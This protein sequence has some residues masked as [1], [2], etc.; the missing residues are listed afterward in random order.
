MALEAPEQVVERRL[1][2][3]R[4]RLR[5]IGLG[6]GLGRTWLAAV[7]AL[8]GVVAL[9]Y[10]LN[11]PAW[12]RVVLTLAAVAGVLWLCWRWMGQGLLHRLSLSDVAGRVEETFPELEDRLRSA[13]EFARMDAARPVAP[14]WEGES[15]TLRQRVR[16]EAAERVAALDLRRAADATPAQRWL[17]RGGACA[18]VVA[19]LAA[20]MPGDYRAAA[21]QRLTDPFAG[22][23]WPKRTLIAVV[24]D[25]PERVAAGDRVGVR[26]RLERGDRPSA[27]AT[28]FYQYDNGAVRQELMTR[29]ADGTFAA[30]LDARVAGDDA[31]LLRVWVRA[32]DDEKRLPTVTVVPRLAVRRV[33]LE[34]APP[35]Y[36]RGPGGAAAEQFDLTRSAVTVVEGSTVRL[37]A[38]FNKPLGEHFEVGGVEP[39]PTLTR[40]G[41]VGQAL[42]QAEKSARLSL[43]ATDTDGFAMALAGEY[44]LLVRPDQMPSV[45]IERPRR[46]EERTARA[47]VPLEAVAEDDFAVVSVELRV[48]RLGDGQR[49]TIPLMASGEAAAGA[50][51]Q[52]V[53]SGPGRSRVRLLYLWSLAELFPADA[54]GGLR[55]GDVLEYHLAAKDNFRLPLPGGDVRTHPEATSSR[56]RIVIVS[57]AELASRL[58]DEMRQMAGQV[59]QLR[60]AQRRTSEETS[61]LRA[62]VASAGAMDEARQRQARRLG[63][64]QST[65]ASQSRQLAG[66]LDDL[67]R[68]MAENRL[69]ASELPS[70]ARDVRDLLDRAAEGPMREATARL[71]DAREM[72]EAAPRDA[73]LQQTQDRQADAQAML[74]Q[75]AERLGSLGTLSQAMQTLQRLLEEQQAVGR[76]TRELAR[77]NLGRRPEQ[78]SAEDREKLRELSSRQ[79][80]L[81]RRTEEALQQMEQ[82]A[83]QMEGSDPQGAQALREAG[84]AGRQQNVASAQQRAGSA[85]SQNQPNNAQPDQR[86]AEIG[87]QMMLRQLREAE[88]RKLETLSRQLAELAEQVGILVRR[89]AG[90]NLDNLLLRPE[91]MRRLPEAERAELQQLSERAGAGADERAAA[92]RASLSA[93]Q[94]LTERN[95]RSLANAASRV[96]NGAEVASLLSR[97]A[98]RMERAA[99]LLRGD[100]LAGAYEPPQVEALRVLRQA[101]QLLEQ[102]QRQA[103]EAME[104]RQRETLRAAYEAA[105]VEQDAVGRDTDRI[106]RLADAAAGDVPRAE[107]M[108]LRQL[109]AQQAALAE[110]LTRLE[111]D[112]VELGSTVFLWAHRDIVENMTEA[113]AALD[114]RDAGPATRSR[115]SRVLEQLDA[116][117]A[118]LNIEPYDREFEDRSASSSGGG[119]GQGQPQQRLPGEAELRLLKAMQQMVNRGTRDAAAVA[120]AER[121]DNA[122]ALGERQGT[123]RDL[124]GEMMAK[125]SQGRFRLPEPPE[126]PLP[127]EAASPADADADLDADLLLGRPVD[128]G[129][130][131]SPVQSAADRMAR[132]RHRLTADGDVGEVTQRLQARIL[133]D[134]DT[135]IEEA[136]RQDQQSARSSGSRGGGASK[137]GVQPGGEQAPNQGQGQQQAGRQDGQ[138]G[139]GAKAE[140]DQAGPRLSPQGGDLLE[141]LSEWGAISPRQRQAIIEGASDTPVAKYRQLIEAYYRA[142]AEKQSGSAATGGTGGRSAP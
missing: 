20:A 139:D 62:A 10:V 132:S 4:R 23:A 125:A 77:D 127:E 124:L 79:S 50:D 81:A 89:Q 22:H 31:A 68:R 111:E 118:A 114:R 94:E 120:G 64:Q 33:L 140:A 24:G 71:A 63:E 8:L 56:Q 17:L 40:S 136:R 92:D 60:L 41:S 66:R 51:L 54:Q 88:R 34:V 37:K 98:G 43:R 27:R 142:L 80:E 138:G 32:G 107:Q 14:A 39:M 123:L 44:E 38:E 1:A 100:D 59:E 102:M 74:D 75:A 95:T 3:L 115:Q 91:A 86:Q 141:R 131:R 110:R 101:G 53:A 16:A 90:H 25:V 47:V 35:E 29:G 73:A 9:D 21:W 45:E 5:W 12:P 116:M 84:Q 76:E 109:G 133:E 104:Q 105:R 96:E 85:L 112:L 52:P 135:L 87:L 6:S 70:T 108:R 19:L 69:E 129:D 26:V 106:G 93:G 134:L 15:E 48:E 49:W 46:T 58:A 28:L 13:V 55:P 72:A 36:A 30:T 7:G 57:G 11:L 65:L 121:S 82:Q 119:G 18:A 2:G 97:A 117:I 113:A 137:P 83:R 126:R 130:A 103:R 78:M 128:R 122:K 67:L 61:E 42:W 99:V